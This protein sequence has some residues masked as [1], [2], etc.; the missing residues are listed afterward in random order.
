MTPWTVAA[1]WF[2]THPDMATLLGLALPLGTSALN[3]L[4]HLAVRR[5]PSLAKVH[6][7]LVTIFPDP[8]GLV[9]KIAAGKLGVKVV[10]PAAEAPT[11]LSAGEK[12]S[13]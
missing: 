4:G 5:W 13:P 6:D 1:Q 11:S 2:A 7:V 9:L 10:A 8:A 3:G 12:K